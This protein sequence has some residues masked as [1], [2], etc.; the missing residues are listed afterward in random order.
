MLRRYLAEV[1]DLVTGSDAFTVLAHIDYPA[2]SW[3]R[4]AVAF[5][6]GQ[7]EA[8]FRHALRATAQSGRVLELN[9]ALPLH[10]TILR[11]WREEGGDGITF[12]SDAHDP[13]GVARG[14][15]DAVQLAEAN[16]FRPGDRPYDVWGRG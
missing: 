13:A 4:T 11:W 16:G 8:E 2:R 15:R 3:P 9:T 1:V 10:A 6:P 5:A 7:F 12:G 14:F